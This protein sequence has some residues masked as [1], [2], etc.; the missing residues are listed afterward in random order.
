[1]AGRK[2]GPLRHDLELRRDGNFHRRGFGCRLT[3]ANK[4]LPPDWRF[5]IRQIGYK[6]TSLD[7]V[8]SACAFVFL[9]KTS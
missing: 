4:T 7:V 1:M 3:S 9:R 2:R 8:R 5:K 6:L